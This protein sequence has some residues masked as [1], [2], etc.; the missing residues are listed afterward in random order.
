ML[1]AHCLRRLDT[2]AHWC[3]ACMADPLLG[4]RYRLDRP[5]GEIR[6]ESSYRATRVEDALLVRVRAMNLD[7]AGSD[8]DHAA[9]QTA[10]RIAKLEHRGLPRLIES[11]EIGGG[12]ARLCM[13]HEYV[14]GRTLA[15]LVLAEPERTRDPVWL[16]HLL[17]ELASVL[18]YLHEQS[19]A[20]AHGQISSNT[21][22]VGAGP[23]QRICLL[24]LQLSGSASP[25]A[26]LR[27]LGVLLASLLAGE[28]GRAGHDE[29]DASATPTEPPP[30]WRE[31]V[32]SQ[33]AT[34]IERMLAN[35]PERS[36]TSAALRES[37][38]ELV[39]ARNVDERRSPPTLAR[40]LRPTPRFVMLESVPNPDGSVSQAPLPVPRLA[41]RVAARRPSEDIPVM[42]PEE[43]S[44]E[45]SQAYRATAQLEQKQQ[46]QHTF[47]RVVVMLLVAMI[48][49]LA[50]Y[51][52]MRG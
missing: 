14:R 31:H 4:G 12:Q 6:G 34:L 25:A 32:D 13:I 21:I 23:D 48:A 45:L 42:R 10:E 2:S 52:A 40:P 30:R 8:L 18:A 33:F 15:E 17:S 7:H 3:P 28:G 36:I 44:R 9:R 26:D 46:K 43:L 50:T 39:R 37:A 11:C 29:T 1:C 5:L 51:F 20:L 19:P 16:L 41:S 27:A 49:A 24:D 47:A 35:Q 22:L 38:A